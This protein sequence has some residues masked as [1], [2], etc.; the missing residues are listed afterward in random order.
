MGGGIGFFTPKGGS[1]MAPGAVSLAFGTA[2]DP[3]P[4]THTFTGGNDAAPFA[5]HASS[6]LGDFTVGAGDF[7]PVTF[8]G[9]MPIYV[10]CAFATIL[11]NVG[12]GGTVGIASGVLLNGVA[13][14][15]ETSDTTSPGDPDTLS[16]QQ[17]FQLAPGDTLW[18][19]IR[20]AAAGDLV[21]SGNVIV[22]KL[23]DV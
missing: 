17:V 14:G 1:G 7:G 15:L 2:T 8:V 20:R 12:G 11:V 6:A 9:P 23:G 5:G 4:S 13:T 16:L 18:P 10:L 22:V 19:Y 3:T 21:V